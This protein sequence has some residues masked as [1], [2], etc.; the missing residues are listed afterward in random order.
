[1]QLDEDE[2]IEIYIYVYVLKTLAFKYIGT[3]IT[4]ILAK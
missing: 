1:M 4:T 2:K 3:Y